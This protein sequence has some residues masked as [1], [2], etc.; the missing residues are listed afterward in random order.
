MLSCPRVPGLENEGRSRRPGCRVLVAAPPLGGD[1]QK[2][3]RRANLPG[4]RGPGSSE[5]EQRC[6]GAWCWDRLRESVGGSPG[7]RGWGRYSKG[8]LGSGGRPRGRRRVEVPGGSAAAVP[9]LPRLQLDCA[10]RPPGLPATR[11]GA[12]RVWPSPGGEGRGARKG[13]DSSVEGDGSCSCCVPAR[14][15][16]PNSWFSRQK[17]VAKGWP[18]SGQTPSQRQPVPA[19]TKASS[20]A[21][22]LPFA[23]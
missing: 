15:P 22:L 23:G 16:H 5:E 2:A 12:G 7:P 13:K 6:Q 10:Q 9:A 14:H 3:V 1:C 21:N 11:A 18:V 17:Y 20:L 4:C 19:G 8:E